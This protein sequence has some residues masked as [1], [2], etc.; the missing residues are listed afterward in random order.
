MNKQCPHCR[1]INGQNY[2]FCSG[3]G[4]SFIFDTNPQPL[5]NKNA[6]TIAIASLASLVFFCGMCG[7]FGAVTDSTDNRKSSKAQT[8]EKPTAK[9]KPSIVTLK[10]ETNPVQ[11]KKDKP[12]SKPVEQESK[13][14]IEASSAPVPLV[15]AKKTKVKTKPISKGKKTRNKSHKK[16]SKGRTLSGS[17][18]TAI[19][20]DGTLSF[21]GS[22]RGT[23]SRHKGVARWLK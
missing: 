20:R 22:R 6:F 8:I 23:C 19:C 11:E 13:K 5:K 3:C 9:P 4:Q 10:Q 21:S 17:G 7:L 15:D 16:R 18:A 14:K 12:S 1:K 2:K